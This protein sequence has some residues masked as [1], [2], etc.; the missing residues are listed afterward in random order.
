MPDDGVRRTGHEGQLSRW[1]PSPARALALL[2]GA[3]LFGVGEGLLVGANMGNSPW[4]VLAQGAAVR[5]GWS[6]GVMTNLIGLVVLTLWIPLR[7]R[8]GLGTVSMVFIV[9]M[10]MDATLAGLPE[11][12]S[13]GV[14]LS[15][16]V[17]GILIVAVGTGYYL[18]SALGP[19]PR[20]GLMTGLHRVTGQPLGLTRGVVEVAVLISGAALGGTVGLGTVAYAVFIGPAV[21]AAVRLLSKVPTEQL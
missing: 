9:G 7:Q 17:A 6:V 2:F 14:R 19:G 16:V 1:R 10:S 15:A 20:D 11:L 5:T 12:G 3:S 8:P 13:I 18:G 21:H 4:T